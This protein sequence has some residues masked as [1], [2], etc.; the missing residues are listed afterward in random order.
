MATGVAAKGLLRASLHLHSLALFSLLPVL[1]F[2]EERGVLVTSC[3][4]PN[5]SMASTEALK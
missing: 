5:C 2:Q 4:L 3:D 1:E